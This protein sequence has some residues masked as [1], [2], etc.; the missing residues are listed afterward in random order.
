MGS[1]VPVAC[2]RIPA[3]TELAGGAA[4]LFDPGD[5]ESLALL[6]ER[7]LDSPTERETLAEAGRARAASFTWAETARATFALYAQLLASRA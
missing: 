7:L 4:A 1:G 6:L 3:L 2:S 5:S